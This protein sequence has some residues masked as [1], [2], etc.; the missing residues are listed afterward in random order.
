MVDFYR[1]VN[2]R[3]IPIQIILM[4]FH[5]YCF[6]ETSALHNTDIWEYHCIA[7]LCYSEL[8]IFYV[9]DK[10]CVPQE[11]FS[12]SWECLLRETT[13]LTNIFTYLWFEG[14][15]LFCFFPTDMS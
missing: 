13:Y 6:L 9:G 4:Y 10:L 11:I 1:M 2:H 14:R 5:L 12:N 8:L 15:K 7:Y 3:M